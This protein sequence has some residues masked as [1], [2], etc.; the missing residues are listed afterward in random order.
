MSIFYDDRDDI[1][2]DSRVKNPKK[3]FSAK[4]AHKKWR[5]SYKMGNKNRRIGK[6]S[7][8]S[9]RFE[10]L[11]AE[12]EIENKNLANL[13]ANIDFESTTGGL[14]IKVDE[15]DYKN[16]NISVVASEDAGNGFYTLSDGQSDKQKSSLVFDSLVS[17]IKNLMV[18]FDRSMQ[19]IYKKNGL[20]K[21]TDK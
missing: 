2:V 3:V 4:Q 7:T 13:Y 6:M 21:V 5:G 16:F 9:D 15:K 10:N 12:A 8:L 18:D 20:A 14:E 11:L 1:S 17:D 19:E